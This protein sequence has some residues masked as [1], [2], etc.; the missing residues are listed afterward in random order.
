MIKSSELDRQLTQVSCRI[1][2]VARLRRTGAIPERQAEWQLKQAVGYR[3][4]LM[5]RIDRQDLDLFDA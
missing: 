2:K 5:R 3:A 1:A 4:A